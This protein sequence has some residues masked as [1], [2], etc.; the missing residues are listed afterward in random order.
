MVPIFASCRTAHSFTFE[1]GI[2]ARPALPPVA[3][4]TRS[5]FL[6]S[7]EAGQETGHATLY[8]PRM[9]ATGEGL[10]WASV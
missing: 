7:F 2:A 6:T 5:D 10:L 4:A 9:V 3:H 1:N 8:V